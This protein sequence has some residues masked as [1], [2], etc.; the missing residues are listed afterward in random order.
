MC[1]PA[2]LKLPACW[3]VCAA[4]CLCDQWRRLG[5]ISRHQRLRAAAEW[6][7]Q[8]LQPPAGCFLHFVPMR[9]AVLSPRRLCASAGCSQRCSQRL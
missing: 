5:D 7:S 1:A 8:A 6:A 4:G 9:A 2:H 3:A